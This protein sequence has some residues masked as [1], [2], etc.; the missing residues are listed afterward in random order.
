MSAGAPP[1]RQGLGAIWDGK[2]MLIFGGLG[3]DDTK[4][5]DV[6]AYDPERNA[7]ELRVPDRSPSAPPGRAG[8]AFVLMDATAVIVGGWSGNLGVRWRDVWWYR[9]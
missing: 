5:S 9:P 4:Y 3:L 7:W 6:W 8:C 1:A 2:R